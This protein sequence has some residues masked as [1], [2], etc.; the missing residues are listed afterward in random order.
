MFFRHALVWGDEKLR[1]KV[2]H[3]IDVYDDHKSYTSIFCKK[4]FKVNQ[5]EKNVSSFKLKKSRLTDSLP[6]GKI[7]QEDYNNIYNNRR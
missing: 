2:L 5:Q 6:D 4:S 3:I 7:K 1:K